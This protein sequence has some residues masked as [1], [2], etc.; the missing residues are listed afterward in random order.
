MNILME[1][2]ESSNVDSIGYD[3]ESQTL[4]VR[5][6]GGGVYHYSNVPADMYEMLKQS[7]SKGQFLNANIKGTYGFQRVIEEG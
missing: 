5:F 4:A 3:P 7:P 6:H 2:V 1:S